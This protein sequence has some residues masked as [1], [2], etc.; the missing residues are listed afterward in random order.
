MPLFPRSNWDHSTSPVALDNGVRLCYYVNRDQRD[1][2]PQG[3]RAEDRMT[4]QAGLKPN[5]KGAQVERVCSK[6]G[7]S[8]LLDDKHFQPNARYAGGFVKWCKECHKGFNRNWSREQAVENP[9]FWKNRALQKHHTTI[10]WYES[11]VKEQDGHCAMCQAVTS[12]NGE[13][14]GID[15]NHSHCSG[16]YGCSKCIRGLLCSTCNAALGYLEGML[17]EAVFIPKPDTWLERALKYL[18]SYRN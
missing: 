18:D 2:Q 14:L 4:E 6:C 1:S 5:K 9:D 8:K 7:T 17:K 3:N 13:R 12:K 10:E 11:K 16:K 15:H